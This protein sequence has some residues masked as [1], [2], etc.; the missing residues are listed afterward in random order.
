MG[1]IREIRGRKTGGEYINGGNV[2]SLFGTVAS[3]GVAVSEETS[4][5]CSAVYACVRVI[6]E[7]IASLPLFVYER[8]EK[9]KIK[10]KDHPL[11]YL[12]HSQPNPEITSF[13]FRETLQAHLCLYGNAFAEIVWNEGG[14]VTELYPLTPS[15]V[16]VRRDTQSN[17]IVYDINLPN[18]GRT[19][20]P[21]LQILHIR[22]LSPNGVVGYSPISLAREGIGL[23]LA[24]EEYAGRFF[25]NDASPGGV[26]E[27]PGQLSD[28]AYER[29]SHFWENKHRGLQ[30]AHRTAIL[31]EGMQWKSIA[32]PAKDA[33]FIEGRKFQVEEIARIFRVPPHLIAS[34]DRSTFSNI[35]NQS[36]EFVTHC[37]R[38]WAVRWEQELLCQLFLPSERNQFFAAFLLDGLLRGDTESRYR[39]YAIGRQWGWLSADDIRELEDMNP[40]P[41]GRGDSYLIPLNMMSAPKKLSETQNNNISSLMIEKRDTNF[42]STR[43][44]RK[45]LIKSVSPLFIDTLTRIIRR[46]E[47]DILRYAK[48]VG[49]KNLISTFL[50]TFYN[51]EHPDYV[52]KTAK[53]V[54]TYLGEQSADVA[55]DMIGDTVPDVD[56]FV[57]SILS[58]FTSG[59]CFSAKK[60]LQNLLL[61][62]DEKDIIPEFERVFEEWKENKT[63]KIKEHLVY[64]INNAVSLFVWKNSGVKLKQWVCGENESPF[65]QNL[66]GK[67]VSIDSVFHKKGEMIE[68]EGKSLKLWSDIN[69]PPLVELC[70][71]L[72]EPV[73]ENDTGSVSLFIGEKNA[74]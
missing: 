40:I 54:F 66:D 68:A 64:R 36:I 61:T 14:V 25:S 26:L 30:Q 50:D 6:S 4:L 10:A 37:I 29:L 8:L 60:Y 74:V 67:I 58:S 32:I 28:K 51:T 27:H 3:T 45:K 57:S 15:R 42:E 72:V 69:H 23:A 43:K 33:Q 7:T 55:A 63:K 34:L 16:S 18:G 47:A 13:Q 20:L 1:I 11:F 49:E 56:V 41:E 48:K 39:A 71:C 12:L 9:G 5:R 53:S 44:V 31:E 52:I 19:T 22:G 17:E 38:P 70:G 73:I 21:F 62:T 59:Y 35:E 2:F 24:T 65:C 46:E